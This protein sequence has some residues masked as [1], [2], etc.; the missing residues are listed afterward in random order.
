MA[1]VADLAAV[2]MRLMVRMDLLG[3]GR[4]GLKT[5][6]A[7]QQEQRQRKT[8]ESA[9]GGA[10]E[11]HEPLSNSLTQAASGRR[12]HRQFDPVGLF[13]TLARP[14]SREAA[15]LRSDLFGNGVER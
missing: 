12:A 8:C 5:C 10:R 4:C 6:K 2:G 13:L 14:R 15:G 7:D 1:G 9:G 11:W 3:D